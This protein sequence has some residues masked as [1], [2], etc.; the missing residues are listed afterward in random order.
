MPRKKLNKNTAFIL[1]LS[2]VIAIETLLL[3]FLLLRPAPKVVKVPHVVKGRIAIVLDDWGYNLNNLSILDRLNY[4]LT[5]AILPNLAYSQ[6]AA[7]ELKLRGYELILHLPMEPLEKFRLEKNTITT[8]MDEAAILGILSQDLK[9]IPDIKG[10]SNHMGSR[11][12]RDARVMGIIFA[13]LKKKG[14]YFL[15]SFVTPGSVC[16]ELAEKM[17]IR[18][19]ERNVFL[20]VKEEPG[21]IMKQMSKLKARAGLYGQAIGI[22]HD[23]KVTLAVLAEM[24]PQ[25]EKEGYK[26]V[27]VSELVK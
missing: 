2:I 3:V 9:N 15:D 19:A 27:F 16:A 10:V 21:Y 1:V 5:M 18:F 17:H 13:G 20:D 11:V 23:R 6:K 25:L 14:L 7:R 12:T 4:P 24:M 22:G 8:S 26:F